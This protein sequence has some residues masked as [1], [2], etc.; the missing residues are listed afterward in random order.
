M[1]VAVAGLA[2]LSIL[3]SACA[4]DATEAPATE[5]AEHMDEDEHTEDE[6]ME[7]EEHSM[8]DMEEGEHMEDMDHGVPEDAAA[9]PNPFAA[10]DESV[11][12]GAEI[13]ATN[14]ASCH[15]ETGEGDGPAAASLAMPP[16]DL[17]EGHVQGNSDG[18]LFYIITNGRPDTPMPPWES[19]LTEE[20]RWHV[21]N[22]LRTF[23]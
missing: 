7:A 12:L 11:G 8:E 17:H 14:C 9:V 2:V 15:G 13:F 21:V 5:E 18:A 1:L 10:D 16:A 22:F 4:S 20:Q 6:H 19:V 23:Q 3:V